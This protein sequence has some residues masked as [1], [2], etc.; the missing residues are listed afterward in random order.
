MSALWPMYLRGYAHLQLKSG[1]E[2]TAE[3]QN[4]LDHQAVWTTGVLIPLARLGLARA[5]ALSGDTA[6]SRNAYED[7]LNRWKDADV[8]IPILQKAKAEYSKLKAN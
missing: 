4:L 7:F 2:A 6:K 1:K 5:Y 8:D 3:F